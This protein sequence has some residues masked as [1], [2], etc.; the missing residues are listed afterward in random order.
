MQT[1]HWGPALQLAAFLLAG[2]TTVAPWAGE[3]TVGQDCFPDDTCD[4]GL[5]CSAGTCV[6]KLSS[7]SL[8]GTPAIDAVPSQTPYLRV[9][10]SGEAPVGATAI[11]VSGAGDLRVATVTQRRFCLE[12][13]LLDERTTLEVRARDAEGCVSE[14]STVEI[15][16]DP[17][18]TNVLA[19]L[20]PQGQWSRTI[21]SLTDGEVSTSLRLS[22]TDP[23]EPPEICDDYTYVWFALPNPTP[24]ARVVVYYP[25]VPNFSDYAL[26]WALIGS[27]QGVVDAPWPVV[28]RTQWDVIAQSTSGSPNTLVIDMAEPIEVQHLALLMFENGVAGDVEAFE[29][30]ELEAWSAIP[31]TPDY[32]G[33]N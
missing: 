28:G 26:C 19:G 18:V 11:E 32:V 29:I 14:A 4:P 2:C 1:S 9:P 16:R 7:C 23:G 22:F 8:A 21:T 30:A 15:T 17:A 5:T 25:D 3:G 12:V 24:I 10:I 13:P 27:D 31:D 6:A 33:C 20:V